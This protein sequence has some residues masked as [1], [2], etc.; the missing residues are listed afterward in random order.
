MWSFCCPYSLQGFTEGCEVR[1]SGMGTGAVGSGISRLGFS[2]KD[3]DVC[4]SGAARLSLLGALSG[5]D[6]KSGYRGYY[7]GP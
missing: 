1:E 2:C 5:L 7:K 3:F 6:L 4:C